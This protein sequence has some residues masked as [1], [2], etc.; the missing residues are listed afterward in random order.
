MK[1]TIIFVLLFV[2]V[3]ELNAFDNVLVITVDT[4]RPDYVGCYSAAKVK[5]PN[6]DSLA[7]NGILFKNTVSPVP[8]TL[9]S[10]VSIFTG[11]LP[12]VHGVQD[13]GGFYLNK[14]IV[15]MAEVFQKQGMHTA[16]FVAA[17]PLDSR[18]GIDQGFEVYDD[19]YPT[20]TASRK[21]FEEAERN[22]KVVADSALVWLQKQTKDGW[23][24]W[25][26]F[27]DPH[28]PYNPPASFQKMY[29][30]DPY[31]GEV[32]YVDQQIGRI[33]SFLKSKNRDKNTLIVFTSDHGESLGEH[34]EKT[35]GVFAYE[36]TIRV[37]FII[38]PFAP[39]VVGNRVRLIDLAPTILEL[40]KLSFPAK[41]QGVSLVPLISGNQQTKVNDSYFEALTMSFKSGW[42]PL[43]GFYSA[44]YKYISLPIPE[45]YDLTVDP[46]ETKNLCADQKLCQKWSAQFDSFSKPFQRTNTPAP[47]DSETK[48]QLRALGYVSETSHHKKEFTTKDDPKNL[49]AIHNRVHLAMGFH[50][51][52]EN[53]KALEILQE[54][55]AERPNYS[56]AYTYASQIYSE[57]GTPNQ[58]VELLNKAIDKGVAG[59]DVRGKLAL[60]LFETGKI[61]DSIKQLK[62]ALQEDPYNVD[63]LNYL[64]M[65][66]S[67]A[68]RQAESENTFRKVLSIDPSNAN[69]LNNLGAL[70][71][72]QEKY[73]PAIEQFK[74]ALK[75]DPHIDNAY[76]GLGIAYA[77]QKKWNDAIRIW[78]M[79]LKDNSKN[80][81]AMWNLALAYM[82]QNNK[83]KALELIKRFQKDA[84]AAQY[85][86]HFSQIPSLLQRLNN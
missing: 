39:K 31:A 5:T 4:L 18:F 74:A 20:V 67:A 22:A 1:L 48:E 57:K 36:S 53:D 49:I 70:Y 7:T 55:I 35:H 45:L 68:G 60:Y 15:T 14:K 56:V 46:K 71:L 8:Y 76:S 83:P 78:E 17:F 51:K 26:H 84:P 34:E 43:H 58:A 59:P 64:G 66:H 50:E 23:F 40:Q 85:K 69:A 16:A 38:S 25:I 6:I 52:G 63:C 73:D 27:Y 44:N 54:V 3:V 62:F 72:S 75:V 77:S 30:D 65:A 42:A 81:D 82:N 86:D 12:P 19:S 13:N 24:V 33:L 37:P 79:G 61:D 21:K 11:L 29:P 28:F 32:A 9:P 41:I 2:S 80:F 10:H 47:I